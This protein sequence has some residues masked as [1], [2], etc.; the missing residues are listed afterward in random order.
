MLRYAH[1][2]LLCHTPS[3]SQPILHLQGW[4]ALT[5]DG[6]VRSALSHSGVDTA[7]NSGCSFWMGATTTEARAG[8]SDSTCLLALL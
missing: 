7:H 8:L 1:L 4:L 3:H 2:G 6:L 5:R